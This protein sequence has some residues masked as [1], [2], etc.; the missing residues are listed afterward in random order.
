MVTDF[1]REFLH[2]LSTFKKVEPV[3][4]AHAY[5]EFLATRAAFISQ[6]KLYEYVKQR[7]GISYPR[8]FENAEFITSLNIAKWHVYAACLSDFGI[9]MGSQLHAA[10]GGREE[11]VEL[12][13][14]AFE[15]AVRE[16]I[17][18]GEFTGE[19]DELIRTFGD[20]A[21]LTDWAAMAEGEAAFKLSPTELVR[22]APIS[23]KL[24]NFDTE[25][26]INSLRFAWLGI[27]DQFRKAADPQAVLAD[28][29]RS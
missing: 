22:W 27:R 2:R 5:N 1:I 15:H 8:M 13:K 19:L 20:R 21:A 3:D 25:I 4:S 18:P 28:W 14:Q 9:W 17:D 16:R 26:V 7:M 23:E 10:G 12:S 11:V 6:K 24:K 29:R